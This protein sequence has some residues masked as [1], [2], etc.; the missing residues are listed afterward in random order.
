M[1]RGGGGDGNTGNTQSF[2]SDNFPHIILPSYF[3]LTQPVQT[4]DT[5]KSIAIY[6]NIVKID[7]IRNWRSGNIFCGYQ[8]LWFADFCPNRIKPSKI[9]GEGFPPDSFVTVD[10]CLRGSGL[11][12]QLCATARVC[13]RWLQK[14]VNPVN[15]SALFSYKSCKS[16]RSNHIQSSPTKE[17]QAA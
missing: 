15:A 7:Y 6:W 11:I 14:L 10:V 5:T 13:R 1:G 3:D 12:C 8:F 4:P 9:S 16:C 2:W 17:L